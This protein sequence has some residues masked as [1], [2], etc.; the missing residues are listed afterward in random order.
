MGARS[1]KSA[2]AELGPITGLATAVAVLFI[3][4]VA[5]AGLGLAVVNALYDNA[6]GTFTIV[7]TIPIAFINGAVF[8]KISPRTSRRNDAHWLGFIGLHDYLWSNR[9][10]VGVGGMVF[11]GPHH[12]DLVPRLVWVSGI[13]SPPFG[14]SWSLEIICPHS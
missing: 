5:L 10:S 6:W 4:V 11:V 13:R 9:G 14:S 12:A 3:V 7:M 8:T 1:Q 2:H